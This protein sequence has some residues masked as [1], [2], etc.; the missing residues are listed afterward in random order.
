MRRGSLTC[1]TY[2]IQQH[3]GFAGLQ[4]GLPAVSDALGLLTGVDRARRARAQR[5]A[6]RTHA[7]AAARARRPD[8]RG[9]VRRRDARRRRGGHAA[10]GGSAR[11]WPI[12]RQQ[13]LLTPDRLRC[14]RQTVEDS[15]SSALLGSATLSNSN[16]NGTAEKVTH[17]GL[18]SGWYSSTAYSAIHSVDSR[19][20]AGSGSGR[21]PHRS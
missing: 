6:A 10:V 13:T 15:P 4:L 17:S 5:C 2:A 20:A 21:G 16:G 9:A 18:G 11:A 19:A 7:H 12:H 3:L 1:R 14:V 8:R